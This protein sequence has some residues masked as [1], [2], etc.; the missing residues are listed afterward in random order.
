MPVPQMASRRE[1]ARHSGSA[2]WPMRK[3]A[4]FYMDRKRKG[5][6]EGCAI[7]TVIK[8]HSDKG[9]LFARGPYEGECALVVAD[10]CSAMQRHTRV[11]SNVSRLAILDPPNKLRQQR[12]LHRNT[13]F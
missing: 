4:V 6:L 2:P 3:S 8:I 9:R 10:S 13:L 7:E 1:R 12:L 5:P 11:S